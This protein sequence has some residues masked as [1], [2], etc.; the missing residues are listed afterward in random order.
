MFHVLSRSAFVPAVPADVMSDHVLLGASLSAILAAELVF[1]V[2]DCRQ[3]R[4]QRVSVFNATCIVVGAHS[5]ILLG[6]T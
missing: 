1:L 2:Q 4:P 6:L 5:L 3:V